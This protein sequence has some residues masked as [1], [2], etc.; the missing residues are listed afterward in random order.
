MRKKIHEQLPIVQPA[1]NHPHAAE[2]QMMNELIAARP[3]VVDL[4][5]ADLVRDLDDPEKGREGMMTA[6]Q[7]FKAVT[8]KQMNGY[9][10]VELAFH[11]EDSKSYRA[12]CGFGIGDEIPAPST[13]QRDI[14]K[15]RPETLEAKNREGAQGPRGLFGG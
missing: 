12:Y 4:V 14:K 6:E 8:I 1:V 5:Y 15:L 11:L 2:L 7:V 3:E 9:S 13:L 10:Y